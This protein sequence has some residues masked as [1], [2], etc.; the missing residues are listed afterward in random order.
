MVVILS[1]AKD[2]QL[3]GGAYIV[4]AA[5]CAVSLVAHMPKSGMYAPPARIRAGT[6]TRLARRGGLTTLSRGERVGIAR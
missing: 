1:A 2:L 5:M 4:L 6:L 3:V